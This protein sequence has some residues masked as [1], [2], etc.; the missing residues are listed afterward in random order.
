M[1]KKVWK[2]S[3]KEVKKRHEKPKK[4]SGNELKCEQLTKLVNCL[5]VEID[6]NSPKAVK[7]FSRNIFS[8]FELFPSSLRANFEKTSSEICPE[9]KLIEKKTRPIFSVP[10]FF[11][12]F[13][14]TLKETP[15][16]QFAR[17]SISP[18]GFLNAELRR[19][20]WPLLLE[21]FPARCS[22]DFPAHLYAKSTAAE[23]TAK[24]AAQIRLDVDRSL[25]KYVGDIS[26]TKRNKMKGKLFDF[27]HHIFCKRP[28]LF[29]YQGF[30][31]V[32]SV[33]FLLFQAE[34]SPQNFKLASLLA[35]RC[36]LFYLR[37]CLNSNLHVVLLQLALIFPLLQKI[38]A[39]LHQKSIAAFLPHLYPHF[40]L[41]W[42]LTW[43]AY[44]IDDFAQICRVFDFLLCSH[45]FMPIY[46]SVAVVVERRCEVIELVRMRDLERLEFDYCSS[47]HKV[48]CAF[49]GDF[50]WESVIS[51][52]V[53]Y[54]KKFPP[55]QLAQ[56]PLISPFPAKNYPHFNAKWSSSL[57]NY[58]FQ[59]SQEAICENYEENTASQFIHLDS[60]PKNPSFPFHP[61]LK[62][63][64]YAFSAGLSL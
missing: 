32:C 36:A 17:F 22:P 26:E 60:T 43:F 12:S 34:K 54:F 5:L 21:I 27:I 19:K 61:Y 30:H 24:D 64:V 2:K 1:R 8:T 41:S 46:M 56:L 62:Y 38:D 49:P 59:W 31:D 50:S 29:Y 58:P 63:A 14:P 47:F 44:V 45:P 11:P 6:C 23:K 28:K 48:F 42:L 57:S 25:R 13:S 40:A 4:K 33:F 55:Q 18:G 51:N 20:I 53:L 52:S 7:S 39:D 35:E 16:K 9:S 3:E 10:H 37:D 15:Q